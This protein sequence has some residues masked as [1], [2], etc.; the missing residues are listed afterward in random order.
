MARGDRPALTAAGPR[1]PARRSRRSGGSSRPGSSA[2]SPATPATSRSPRTSPRR[3]WPRRWSPGRATA[4]PATRRAG[5]SRS[6]GGGRSTPSAAGRRSTSGTPRSPA[7]G[8]GAD[9]G[10]GVPRTSDDLPW[11]PDRIDDDVL[12]LMF[13]SCHP[14]LSPEARVALTLRVV[15]GLT[16][17]E[18]ARA[19]LVPAPTVQ[20]RI[21]RAKK[22]IAA[23]QVPFELPP[24][25]ERRE[26]LGVGAQRALRDLHRGLDG[27]VRRPTAS[28]P[29]SP[30]RRSGWPGCWPR[31]CPTSPRCTGC[32]PCC[33]LTAARF[34]ARTGPDGEPVLLEDQDRRR[35][36][37]SAIRR[38][39]AALGRAAA[40]GRGL[41]A[42]RAAGRDRR[43]PR[44]R[45]RRSDDTDWERIVLLYEAL[46]RLAPS[47]VVELNRAVAVAM[48]Q[49][50]AAG[51]ADRR[52]A[53]RH[54]PARRLAPAAERARRA[55]RPARPDRR[56]PGRART[57]RPA[58]RQRPGAGRAPAQ[59]RRAGLTPHP[60]KPSTVGGSVR[61]TPHNHWRVT[62]TTKL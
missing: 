26:R 43:V 54:G 7:T 38:G 1:P 41:G 4:Y 22:T 48:A 17:E 59:A 46:G 30:T 52:R 40:L 37:R 32:S 24:P 27:D 33:E 53:G 35:W 49:G 28:A 47:P 57:G 39:R 36:D 21:T 11:D 31:C 10:G 16:S 25:E 14:V 45:R 18:I 44:G 19:F 20:A 51:A 2:R 42:V 23:A 8:E 6:P 62:W 58:V 13:V 9:D 34:P 56:G 3:R 50:P 15:G 61:H 5:C 12:A 29:T 60:K 55:A